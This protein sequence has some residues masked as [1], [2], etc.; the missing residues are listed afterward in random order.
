MKPAKPC[1]F[2]YFAD[3][4]I[5]QS[6][7]IITHSFSSRK[8]KYLF[9]GHGHIVG[10]GDIMMGNFLKTNFEG[11]GAMKEIEPYLKDADI[12][13]GNLEGTLL[14]RAARKTVVIPKFV[15]YSDAGFVRT[16][17]DA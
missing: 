6:P 17:P 16:K 13:F 15:T 2:S 9:Q 10:V 3:Y 12:T 7:N 5:I 14:D 1:V 8:T 11:D 4:S